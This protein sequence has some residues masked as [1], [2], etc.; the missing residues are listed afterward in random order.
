MARKDSVWGSG[1]FRVYGNVFV[2]FTIRKNTLTTVHTGVYSFLYQCSHKAQF[3][4]F[5]KERANKGRNCRHPQAVMQPG[6]G[7]FPFYREKYGDADPSIDSD[8]HV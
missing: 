3:V 2:S 8:W 7:V 1:H 5:F 6:V 4:N